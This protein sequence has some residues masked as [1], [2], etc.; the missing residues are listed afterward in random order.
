MT[1]ESR[2]VLIVG[3]G[4]VG[5]FL[6]LALQQRGI[7]CILA[8]RRIT[9]SQHSRA[10]GIHPPSMAL[11][12]R[13]GLAKQIEDAG[14]P[15]VRGLAFCGRQRLGEMRFADAGGDY[16]YIVSVPQYRT[17]SLMR[18]ALRDTEARRLQGY[19]PL[20]LEEHDDHVA[21]T[22]RNGVGEETHVRASYVI[23]CDGRD[24]WVRSRAGIPWRGGQ[25]RDRYMMGDFPDHLPEPDTARIYVSGE[26]LVEAI[27][28]PS[29]MRRWVLR[30][31]R[32]GH[33]LDPTDF[34]REVE[35]RTGERLPGL[36]ENGLTAF[37]IQ[38]FVAGR[39]VQG[40]LFLAGDAAHIM[41]PI[42][43]QGMNTGWMDAWELAAALA[44]ECDF[45]SYNRI[46]RRRAAVAIRR[47]HHNTLVGRPSSSPIFKGMFIRTMLNT[48]LRGVWLRRFTMQGLPRLVS[49]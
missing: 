26:G 7:P 46:V 45:N 4:P 25:Y 23:G 39:V 14:C 37:G 8:D 47:A 42:G 5:L 2:S 11:F 1:A 24:S 44:G 33:Q 18:D 9:D 30:T 41:S 34:I 3:A 17:E 36:P 22:L 32:N 40:R 15:I 19:E 20:D 13:I 10:I 6:G 31:R 28:L 12:E 35:R 16:P 49:A 29:G 38:H 27:P 48:P 21:V 43:G